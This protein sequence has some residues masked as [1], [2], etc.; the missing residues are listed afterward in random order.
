MSSF[1]SDNILCDMNSIWM[2]DGEPPKK[3]F[4]IN[5]PSPDDFWLFRNFYPTLTK[6]KIMI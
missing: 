4:I 5:K 6:L 2:V 1:S 3:K